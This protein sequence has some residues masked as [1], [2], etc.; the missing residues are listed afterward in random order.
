MHEYKK[1][2]PQWHPCRNWSYDYFLRVDE[3]VFFVFDFSL[4]LE[5]EA[6]VVLPL[7]LLPVDTDFV[8]AA[9]ELRL[10]LTL[11]VV[12]V[13]AVLPEE[14][15]VDALLFDETVACPDF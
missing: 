10:A 3:V 11:C 14:T 2:A 1:R 12:L 6:F 13:R 8:L 7:L 4:L 9:L 15:L 5:E